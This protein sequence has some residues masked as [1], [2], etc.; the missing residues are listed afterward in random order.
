MELRTIHAQT[1]EMTT[2]MKLLHAF[3]SSESVRF[4]DA[5]C[6][7][8]KRPEMLALYDGDAMC[9]CL[10]FFNRQSSLVAFCLLCDAM[11]LGAYYEERIEKLLKSSFPDRSVILQTSF[12]AIRTGA[13]I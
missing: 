4:Y 7:A 6:H 2:A 11:Y 12:C 10:F 5:V 9:G 1:D 13:D 8:R 3:A